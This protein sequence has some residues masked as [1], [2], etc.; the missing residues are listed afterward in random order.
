MIARLADFVQVVRRAEPGFTVIVADY[1]VRLI[2]S[3]QA[4]QDAQIDISPFNY[5]AGHFFSFEVLRDRNDKLKW[6]IMSTPPG[7]TVA[8]HPEAMEES[9]AC[10]M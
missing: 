3:K 1:S 8:F 6:L 2:E 4:K 10:W 7:R 5:E 9:V